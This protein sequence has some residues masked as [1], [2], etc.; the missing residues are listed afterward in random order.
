MMARYLESET[1]P[2]PEDGPDMSPA[3]E[4]RIA[5]LEAAMLYLLNRAEQYHMRQAKRKGEELRRPPELTQHV[6]AMLAAVK[7]RGR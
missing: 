6:N 1:D 7:G 5:A 2:G 3:A 4:A